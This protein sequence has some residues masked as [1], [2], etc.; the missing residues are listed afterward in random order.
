M[1]YPYTKTI[2]LDLQ[3]R[4]HH[5]LVLVIV[6]RPLTI[7]ST[8]FSVAAIFDTLL[9]PVGGSPMLPP[10]VA[11][12]LATLM[13]SV[14]DLLSILEE[15]DMTRTVSLVVSHHFD[16]SGSLAS[17]VREVESWR[18]TQPVSIV[19]IK[20]NNPTVYDYIALWD[21]GYSGGHSSGVCSKF[22]ENMGILKPISQN[23]NMVCFLPDILWKHT[24]RVYM[25]SPLFLRSILNQSICWGARLIWTFLLQTNC[26][27]I[28]NLWI[29][30]KRVNSLQFEKILAFLNIGL[31]WKVWILFL[32]LRK[33]D[34]FKK[35]K[36]SWFHRKRGT[37]SP[38]IS[39]K[40]VKFYM[41]EHT[42]V[43]IF[44]IT[45]PTGQPSRGQMSSSS[46]P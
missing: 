40:E 18:W 42:C 41:L 6:Y 10:G 22:H 45:V 23:G 32:I 24:K 26:L 25:Q 14:G 12:E 46:L 36:F 1:K 19:K 7:T 30:I 20:Q 44:H 2:H 29:F 34:P 37:F 3:T 31:F 17:N 35:L 28:I 16:T 5:S 4:L 38:N 43:P 13:T 8:F 33:K 15:D 39:W 27:S 11:A 21:E 9:P